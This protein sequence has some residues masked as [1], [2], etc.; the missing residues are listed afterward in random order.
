MKILILVMILTVLIAPIIFSSKKQKK[1]LIPVKIE[2]SN[3]VEWVDPNNLTPG[4]HKHPPFTRERR[5]LLEEI[6]RR[7]DEVYPMSMEEWEDGFRRD[8]HPDN[9]IAIW[10]NAARCY[11]KFAKE[12]TDIKTKEEIY[13]VISACMTHGK[14]ILKATVKTKIISPEKTKQILESYFDTESDHDLITIQ[15]N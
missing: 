3:K 1:N 2:G 11:S 7:L 9:E 15:N 4:D 14:R 13:A 8:M 5:V 10:L 12:Y 6:K